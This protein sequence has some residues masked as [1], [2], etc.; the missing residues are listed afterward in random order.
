MSRLIRIISAVV[1]VV[2]AFAQDFRTDG[3]RE[4]A[5]RYLGARKAE[6]DHPVLTPQEV[7][8][9]LNGT[10]R[11]YILDLRTESDFKQGR[12]KGSHRIELAELLSDDELDRLPK[13]GPIL[14]VDDGSYEAIEAMV[15]L[16]LMGRKVQAVAGGVGAIVQ[17]LK[18]A[19]E[20]NPNG[21]KLGD[22]I[23]GSPEPQRPDSKGTDVEN[24]PTPPSQQVSIPIW[25]FIAMGGM[26]LIIASG[27]LWLFV[28]HPRRKAKP[29]LDAIQ[30]LSSGGNPA[31]TQAEALLNQ[32]LNGG[33]KD[34][35]VREARFL[36]AYVKAR[37][38]RHGDSLLLLSDSNHNSLESLYLQLWLTVK[39]KRWEEAERLCFSHG[40]QLAGYLKGKELMGIVYLEL[41]RHAMARNQHE[42]ALD[43]F[44]KV[45]SLGVFLDQ[46]PEHLADLEMVLAMSAL[47]EGIEK[48]PIARERFDGARKSAE[49]SGKSSLLPRIGLLLC[50]WRQQERP[51]IDSALGTIVDQVKAASADEKSE[52]A[53]ILPT[54]TLWYAVSLFYQWLR[55]LPEKKGLPLKEREV[56][57]QRLG[58][59]R[60][61]AQ[62]EGDPY[63]LGGLVD[64]Y[65]APDEKRRL[66]A[67]ELLRKAIDLGVNLPEVLYLVQCEDRLAELSKHRFE[68]Y[69]ALLRGFLADP[70]VP[71]ELR[72]EL[73]E[74][75]RKFE[76]FKNLEEIPESDE[77][78]TAPSVRDVAI[79]CE[80]LEDRMQRIFRG[81]DNPATRSTVEELLGGLRKTRDELNRTVGELGKTEQRLMRVAGESLLPEEAQA[82]VEAV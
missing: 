9:Q 53:S 75:L 23:D 29:L 79:A 20:K 45:K 11:P 74:H 16:G 13:S 59:A 7:A 47:F 49:S 77:A 42:R 57:E 48:C 58:A 50:D 46:V 12:L 21:P 55:R 69:M 8:Q 31:L 3:L 1:V 43:C 51:D 17:E 18:V 67:V 15:L 19:A 65:C 5:A 25:V 60:Q 30:L 81:Y 14:V 4:S 10:Q 56:L 73:V 78:A 54:I 66:G 33:L 71:L 64:Y 68:T 36:L 24:N 41:A 44:Q 82:Q 26:V 72:R 39:E 61:Q 80:L 62:K 63:L 35:E 52:A 34:A 22:Q 37:L 38:G 70:G 40:T 28:L 76:R 2:A 27:A 6:K 32:A